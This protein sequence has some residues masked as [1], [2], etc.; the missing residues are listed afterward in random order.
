MTGEKRELPEFTASGDGTAVPLEFAPRESLLVVFRHRAKASVEPVKNFPALRTIGELAGAWTVAF[1]PR[2]GGP[3]SVIFDSL[4]YWTNRPE[5]GIKFY[6]GT[7][8]YRKTFDLPAGASGKTYLDLCELHNLARVRLNGQDL[9]L[10]WCAPWHVDITPAVK[11]TGNELELEVVNTWANRIIGDLKLPPEQRLT[12]TVK[13]H[14]TANSPLLPAGLVG[15][16]TL[17]AVETVPVKPV[18]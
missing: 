6:S 15:P 13:P 5:A 14:F 11:P 7:A 2:W 17:Q 12:W 3:A 10:V 18:R 4:V 1:D 9:G 16:V 8:K